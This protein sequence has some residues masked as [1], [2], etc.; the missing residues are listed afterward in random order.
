MTSRAACRACSVAAALAVEQAGAWS[1]CVRE[2]DWERLG[3][4]TY[5]RVRSVYVDTSHR[6]D[7]Y[8]LH[9]H[10]CANERSTGDPTGPRTGVRDT[11]QG[12]TDHATRDGARRRRGR[13]RP[14][15]R[16]GIYRRTR[17]CTPPRR[18]S[19]SAAATAR[20]LRGIERV[21]VRRDETT[22]TC[23]TNGN[24]S[25][26]VHVHA[27]STHIPCG[28]PQRDL[29]EISPVACTARPQ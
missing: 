9:V 20:T 26:L 13:D 27:G 5:P 6:V 3:P 28:R 29:A 11:I 24:L 19:G 18:T 10:V 1:C 16:R 14:E 23:F 12:S 8:V 22:F 4:R 25:G 17:E 7:V 2:S 21:A 15:N